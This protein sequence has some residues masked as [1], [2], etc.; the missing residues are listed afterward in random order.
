M[1]RPGLRDY[2]ITREAHELRKKN[3]KVAKAGRMKLMTYLSR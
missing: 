1:G 2:G 3:I